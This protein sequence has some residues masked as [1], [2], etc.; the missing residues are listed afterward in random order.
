MSQ[1]E[2]E[3]IAVLG[4]GMGSLAAV[5]AL[6][7]QPGW[8]GRQEITVYQEGWLLGGKGASTRNRALGDRIEE[9]GLHIWLGFYENAFRAIRDV[10]AELGRPEGAPLATFEAAF[11]RQSYITLMEETPR[12]LA[13]WRYQGL[14]DG[15]IPGDG[16]P[17]PTPLEYIALG[18]RQVIHLVVSRVREGRGPAPLRGL[19]ALARGVEEVLSYLG[20]SA[21]SAGV[22]LGIGARHAALQVLGG[23]ERSELLGRLASAL[24][25]LA[26]GVSRALGR[27]GLDD[28]DLRRMWIG[29]DFFTTN[30]IGMIRE[31]LTDEDA[32][33]SRLDGEEYRAWL[34]RHGA[35]EVTI[36][37]ALIK[38]IYNIAFGEGDGGG[39]GTVLVGALRMLLAYRGA[40]YWKMN[41]GMGETIFAPLY[42]ALSARGVRF[43]FFHRVK[44]LGLS[45]DR[46]QVARVV[47][48]RQATVKGGGEYAPLVDVKGLCCWPEAPLA[49]QLEEGEA[50]SRHGVRPVSLRHD[51][52][53]AAE[54]TLHLGRDFD[55][56][57]LGIS[58]GGLA[59]LT[60]ELCEA[61]PRWRAMLENVRT[62][63]THA[64][65]LWLGRDAEA[66]RGEAAPAVIG[67]YVAP[68]DTCADMSHL[69]PQESWGDEVRHI[70]YLCG[71]AGDAGAPVGTPEE[72]DR[73]IVETGTAWLSRHA[74][75]I[76]P[77]GADPRTGSLDFSLLHDPEGR[78]GSARLAAQYFRANSEGSDRYVL[79]VAG[80]TQHRLFADDTGFSNLHV[81]GDW[82][83]TGL[84]AGC[85]EAAT[86]SGLQAARA[87]LGQTHP[88][89]GES[90]LYR[91]RLAARR[92][93][94]RYVE[95]PDEVVLPPPYLQ[96]GVQLDG[97][98]LGAQRGA[99]QDLVDARLNVAAGDS[100]RFSVAAP[101]VCL[102]S[103]VTAHVTSLDPAHR[104]RGRMSEI[105]VG[106]WVPLWQEQAGS[107]RKLTWFLPYLFVDSAASVAAGREVYGFPKS[108][109][110]LE[111]QRDAAGLAE[112]TVDAHAL[113]VFSPEEDVEQMRL[114]TVERLPGPASARSRLL[115]GLLGAGLPL[116]G[117]ESRLRGVPVPMV[118]L[119]QLRDAERPDRAVYQSVLAAEARATALR[120][121]G[122]SSARYRVRWTAAASHPF[123]RDLGLSP[124]GQDSVAAFSADFDFVMG[125]GRELVRSSG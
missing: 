53:D 109:G 9:H 26:S 56:V 42:Q 16:K 64:V 103:A 25:A 90:P 115:D 20:F 13:R 55:R 22:G 18:A 118:F 28:D 4:G 58:L 96:S 36:G 76:F 80:S 71:P 41:A 119:K 95:R 21:L 46:R 43:R 86:M 92:P 10:Y 60:A 5:W 17:L 105:D 99:L 111:L 74:H 98:W 48:G 93:L 88:I 38:G 31:G 45:A 11:R 102:I 84:D 40:I 47:L 68:L 7:S 54:E 124:D 101:A 30:L 70:A 91:A 72:E 3:K 81:A 6:T 44:R 52:P 94:P 63:K 27:A 8:R 78:S 19:A 65:Q 107:E 104:A 35:S 49:D 120:R 57:I 83:R 61:E 106:F 114:L 66:L 51:W 122:L 50:L 113:R 100:L 14:E 39:A 2:R 121:F 23:R 116:E 77:R 97:I 59:P 15:E 12:G 85:V 82:T 110:R 33:F 62:V 32:D 29:V 123:A 87:I 125:L 67:T 1:G 117:L 75:G 108:L 69:I 24:G 79:S 37:S 34:R 73:A 89:L 112:L